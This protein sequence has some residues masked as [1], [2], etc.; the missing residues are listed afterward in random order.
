MENV[1]SFHDLGRVI[2]NNNDTKA[3][4]N[5]KSK[6]WNAY[7]KIKAVLK[8]WKTPM[9]TKKKTFEPY[10]LPCL[11]YGAEIITR[12]KDLLRKMQEQEKN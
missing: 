12:R 3:V 1:D 4:E 10:I 2:T 7:N 8:D 5:L 9:S 6:G 11:M